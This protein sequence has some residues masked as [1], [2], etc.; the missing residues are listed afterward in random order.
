MH[1][2]RCNS[3][4]RRIVRS[5]MASTLLQHIREHLLHGDPAQA[6]LTTTKRS[7]DG[8][9]TLQLADVQLRIR[10]LATTLLACTRVRDALRGHGSHSSRSKDENCVILCGD[11]P[12]HAMAGLACLLHG[13]VA[14]FV[15]LEAEAEETL[16]QVLLVQRASQAS[17]V[18]F[19][20]GVWRQVRP[21]VGT[22]CEVAYTRFIVANHPHAQTTTSFVLQLQQLQPL[23]VASGNSCQRISTSDCTWSA[24]H[25]RCHKQQFSFMITPKASPLRRRSR[26]QLART[27]LA[28][29]Y[30]RCPVQLSRRRVRPVIQIPLQRH[31]SFIGA[32]ATPL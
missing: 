18:L 32:A 27:R 2:S 19:S 13:F 7:Y 22:R 14:V 11:G 31:S 4:C 28:S 1:K 8:D 12:L 3:S 21:F 29:S 15:P 17:A 26:L 9:K 25:Q 23:Q 20:P 6:A 5:A 10:R 30:Q 16:A 24:G